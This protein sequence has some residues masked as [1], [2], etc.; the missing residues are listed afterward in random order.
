MI[1]RTNMKIYEISEAVGYSN[2]EHFTRVFKKITGTT[3]STYIK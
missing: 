1:E 2:V 3:P